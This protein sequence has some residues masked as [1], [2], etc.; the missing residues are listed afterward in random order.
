MAHLTR[1]ILRLARNPEAGFPNG[2]HR[3]GYVMTAPLAHDGHLD[4]DAWKDHRKTCLVTRFSPDP[5]DS[6]DGWLS[7]QGGRWRVHYDE[8]GEGP[9]DEIDH[10]ADHRL[11]VGDYVTIKRRGQE[12]VYQVGQEDDV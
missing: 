3:Y 4:A 2:D 8:A 6:A 10:L 1:I 9:D 7:H 11:F 12:L 5:D